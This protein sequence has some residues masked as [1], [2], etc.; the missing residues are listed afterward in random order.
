MKYLTSL[1]LLILF[2]CANNDHVY[3]CN[4]PQSK[5]YHYNE[6]CYGLKNCSTRIS[7]V[8]METAGRMNR[9]LCGFED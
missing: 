8:S 3:V 7:K 9:T 2:S 5:R 1:S 4:G 6:D